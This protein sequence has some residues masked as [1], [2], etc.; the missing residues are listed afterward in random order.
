M[1]SRRLSEK[2]VD[3]GLFQGGETL[4]LLPLVFF[5]LLLDLSFSSRPIVKAPFVV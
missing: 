3:A 4:A 2:P 1:K 5:L